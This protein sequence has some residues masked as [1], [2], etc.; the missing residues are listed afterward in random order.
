MR[1]PT[2]KGRGPR[3]PFLVL[4]PGAPPG[5]GKRIDGSE[6]RGPGI[7]KSREISD[8]EKSRKNS[9]KVNF[10]LFV[11]KSQLFGLLME[12]RVVYDVGP[13]WEKLKPKGPKGWG[14]HAPCTL[15]G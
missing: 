1:A 2:R 12:G 10:P 9:G 14:Y 8:L 6:Q 4:C 15:L 3:A 13:C 5:I 11:M 7:G